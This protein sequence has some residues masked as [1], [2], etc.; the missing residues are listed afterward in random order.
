MGSYLFRVVPSIRETLSVFLLILCLTV[1][2]GRAVNF[3][4]KACRLIVPR[5][6]DYLVNDSSD[7][8]SP[9][10]ELGNGMLIY[11]GFA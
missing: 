10:D 8:A 2:S 6:W 9:C 7:E 3:S 4:V 1:F 5:S 11:V